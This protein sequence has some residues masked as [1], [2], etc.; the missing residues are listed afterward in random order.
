MDG[1]EW[2]QQPATGLG[3]RERTMSRKLE[4]PVTN[5]SCIKLVETDLLEVFLVE[6][7]VLE[8]TRKWAQLTAPR[9][10]PQVWF[11]FANDVVAT[12]A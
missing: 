12:Q 7:T 8:L 11:K 6:V 1:S 5:P 10:C 2:P 3:Q 9:R 4:P